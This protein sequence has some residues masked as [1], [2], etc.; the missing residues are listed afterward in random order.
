MEPEDLD[1]LYRVENDT[2]TWGVGPTNVPYSRYN[3][4]TYIAESSSDIY[5]DRQ[6]RLIVENEEEVIV[7]IVDLVDFDPKHNRA[8]VG[9]IIQRPF[10]HRGYAR[11]AMEKI[12]D[13]AR[14][15]IHLHQ[16]YAIV[17]QGNDSSLRLFNAL[18]FQQD[19]AL[20]DWLFDGERYCDACVMQYF[21]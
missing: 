17:A 13:Y 21:L 7:G 10:R 9:I 19:M 2:S 18:G 5:T 16:I 14:R 6:V 3:L 8:E 15:V 1:F 12:M 20:K 4:H 11:A